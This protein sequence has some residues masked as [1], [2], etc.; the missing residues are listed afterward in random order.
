MYVHVQCAGYVKRNAVRPED[1]RQD[2]TVRPLQELYETCRR[3]F[4][5]IKDCC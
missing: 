3:L 2:V 1:S 5:M 4:E